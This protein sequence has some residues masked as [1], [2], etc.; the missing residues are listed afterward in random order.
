MQYANCV[1]RARQP[2][3]MGAMFL[4]KHWGKVPPQSKMFLVKHCVLVTR[5]IE[6]DM[7]VPSD[8]LFCISSRMFLVKHSI[9]APR[10]DSKM[11]LVKH[12][13]FPINCLSV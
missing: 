13:L 4:V 1:S 3:Y 7:W 12:S 10:V 2:Q 8:W 5:C 6:F 9:G 11:F